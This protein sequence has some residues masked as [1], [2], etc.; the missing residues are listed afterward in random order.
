MILSGQTKRQVHRLGR[1]SKAT[2]AKDKGSHRWQIDFSL[3][4]EKPEM[5]A[6]FWSDFFP[7]WTPQMFELAG[8][9]SR[10]NADICEKSEIPATRI[11]PFFSNT[12]SAPALYSCKFLTGLLTGALASA[13]KTAGPFMIR[14]HEDAGR[15]EVT[16]RSGQTVVDLCKN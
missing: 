8:T 1:E 12:F 11:R 9:S 13:E 14:W 4:R 10:R 2:S 5:D 7:L 16:H 3:L 6:N 15:R